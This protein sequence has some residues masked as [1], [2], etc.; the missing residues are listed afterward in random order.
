VYAKSPMPEA[1]IHIDDFYLRFGISAFAVV[2][3]Q[4]LGV[5]PA[6]P[7][8]WVFVEPNR[9]LAVDACS[10]KQEEVWM[11]RKVVWMRNRVWVTL[12]EDAFWFRTLRTYLGHYLA[13][14]RLAHRVHFD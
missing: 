13:A 9:V 11:V 4:I 5:V 3:M 8:A 6:S 10:S 2:V 1:R 7:D 12:H 14:L